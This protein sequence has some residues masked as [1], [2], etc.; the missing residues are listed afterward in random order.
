[1]DDRGTADAPTLLDLVDSP[2]WQ[3]LQDHLARVLGV[4]LRTVSPSHEL[5]VA[6]SWPLGLDAERLVSALK[7]GEELEQLIPHGQLPTDTASLTV[8]LGV[9][10]AAVPIRVMP[11]QSVAYFVV[12]PLVVGPR[13]E[14]TQFR[15]R[16]GAMGMDG[17]TLW[18]LLLSMKLYTF[19]GIRSALNLLEEVGTSIVQL[20]YQVRQLTAIFPVGGKM[21]HA[22]TTFYADRVFN[23]LLESAM[24]ATKAD[25]GSVMLYD[26]KRDVFQVKIAQGLQHD[27]VA[28][29][30]VKRGEG[31]AG[32]AAAER[33][34]LLLDEHTAEPELMNRMKR[35]DIVS[36]IVAPLTPEASPEPIGVLNLRTSDPDRKFTQEHVE[37][38]RRLLDLTGIALTNFRPTLSSSS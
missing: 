34:M 18:P 29:A 7:L 8:P 22:V 5:L 28:T 19:S 14:E 37:L 21:D 4:P 3:R 6:P 32:L 27:V 25:A 11:K 9:T 30:T 16:V 2:R 35:R 23:S 13:E 17:Q 38:L 15:H 31:L 33:R 1:M 20:A 26:V 12:G 10:Y 36:S 24:L